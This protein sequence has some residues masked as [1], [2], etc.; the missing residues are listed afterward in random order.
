MFFEGAQVVLL[1]KVE[2]NDGIVNGSR[3]VVIGF[4]KLSSKSKK[5]RGW[6][7]TNTMLPIVRFTNGLETAIPPAEFKIFDQNRA[8]EGRRE[9]KTYRLQ[10]PL[11]LAWA[12]TIHRAQGM[13]LDRVQC[14][15]NHTF[16]PGQ[17]YVALSRVRSLEG[18]YIK[19]LEKR[20][21]ANPRTIFWN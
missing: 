19:A 8:N 10:L 2:G 6:Y 18:L 3:G 7:E 12:L 1:R 16:A 5:F 15:L 11:K 4:E 14:Y 21:W 20:V 17:G 13:T 9:K